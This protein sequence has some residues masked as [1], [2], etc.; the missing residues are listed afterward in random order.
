M[1]QLLEQLER[2]VTSPA[3]IFDFRPIDYPTA[4][5]QHLIAAYFDF[6]A[7]VKTT[8]HPDLIRIL[9]SSTDKQVEVFL[10]GLLYALFLDFTAAYP[11]FETYMP[12]LRSEIWL[13]LDRLLQQLVRDSFTA[14][15]R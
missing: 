11:V 15:K 8:A 7:L 13:A 5:Q 6:N 1:E 9:H 14:I 2:F 3:C 10:P 4:L 12:I